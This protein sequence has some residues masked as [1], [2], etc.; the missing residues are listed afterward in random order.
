M[1]KVGSIV[2]TL[3]RYEIVAVTHS[4]H[5]MNVARLGRQNSQFLKNFG[6]ASSRG[7]HSRYSKVH[8]IGV[9]EGTDL[10]TRPPAA[11]GRER[12]HA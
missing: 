10:F 9:G 6:F 7:M 11:Y 4:G 2:L 5:S 1:L 12:P 8:D 3:E